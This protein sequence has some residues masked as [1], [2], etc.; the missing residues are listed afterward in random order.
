MIRSDAI[1]SPMPRGEAAGSKRNTKATPAESDRRRRVVLV[2]YLAVQ[3][4]PSWVAM[5]QDHRPAFALVN[6][7]NP[8]ACS[9]E[10]PGLEGKRA[11]SGSKS[12]CIGCLRAPGSHR[13]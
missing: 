13:F 12:I 10:P 8:R 6:V 1:V 2:D 3:K 4:A 11:L 7:V 5:E 9:V